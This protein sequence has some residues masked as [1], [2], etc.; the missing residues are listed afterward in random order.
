MTMNSVKDDRGLVDQLVRRYP[1]RRYRLD[2]YK[3][4][5][6]KTA[7]VMLRYLKHFR[8]LPAI[9]DAQQALPDGPAVGLVVVPWVSTPV[10]WYAIMLAIGLARRERRVILFWDDTGF[11]EPRL[12]EQSQ[13][14][15]EVLAYT[16]RFLP[17]VRLT[18]AQD[19]P[20][21]PT[22]EQL[23][24]SLTDQN[25]LWRVR[26]AP[27]SER[28]ARDQQLAERMRASLARSL[29]RIRSALARADLDCLVVPGGIYGTSGLFLAAAREQGC[30]V[31]TF[32]VDRH[33]AQICVSGIAAQHADV[34][35][36]FAALW[37]SGEEARAQ[38]MT[39]ARAEF[40]R[41]TESVDRYGFQMVPARGDGNGNGD[42]DGDEVAAVIPMNVEWDSAALGRHVNF[43]DTIDWITSTVTTILEEDC[44]TVIVRQHPSERRPQQRSRLDIASILQDRF[45]GDPRLR[46]VAADDPANT[47][48][49]LRNARL[50]LPFV[51]TIGIEAAA[52]GMPV[53]VA[54][55]CFYD[56]LG[57]VWSAGSR[58]EYFYLLRRGLRGELPPLAHQSDRAWICYYLA[59][60]Q[61]RIWT[62][63]NTHPD[64]FWTWCRRAP[65]SL[66]A[67]PETADILEAIDRDIPVSLLRHQRLSSLGT[68]VSVGPR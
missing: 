25:L 37:N 53:L 46:F 5:F 27:P 52:M 57:F 24:G 28:T 11:P 14:V 30:R 26:G 58:D 1:P 10:P 48:D 23:I 9:G 50:V 6:P 19:A 29:P 18:E 59:A 16:G 64:D 51:S 39:V 15:A 34:P 66:F 63:F 38:A 54:G 62:D 32:D 41:R 22:D 7:R 68:N 21:R 31:A 67:E 36:A 56:D 20:A 49:L 60:V 8:P 3:R 2:D 35:R 40:T 44:G 12:K 33:T 47:Y 13:A 55:D 65:D 4:W 43:T 42:G 45:G 17:V 61:N